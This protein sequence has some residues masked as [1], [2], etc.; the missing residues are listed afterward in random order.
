MSEIFSMNYSANPERSFV[1]RETRALYFEIENLAGRNELS[2]SLEN[3]ATAGFNA[4]YIEAFADLTTSFPVPGHGKAAV[5]RQRSESA[6]YDMLDYFCRQ[7]QLRKMHAYAVVSL[8]VERPLSPRLKWTAMRE[9]WFRDGGKVLCFANEH[10]R[11]RLGDLASYLV[12][13]YPLDGLFL[14]I[15]PNALQPCTCKQCTNRSTATPLP[16]DSTGSLAAPPPDTWENDVYQFCYSFKSRARKAQVILPLGLELPLSRINE[17]SQGSMKSVFEEQLFCLILL[18]AEQMG[19]D[20]V[21]KAL[22]ELDPKVQEKV[23]LIRTGKLAHF[24]EDWRD[25]GVLG[26]ALTPGTDPLVSFADA[27]LPIDRDPLA[28]ALYFLREAAKA[29]QTDPSF[30]TALLARVATLEA[31]ILTTGTLEA[32][33]NELAVLAESFEKNPTAD[34]TALNI[35]LS[36]ANRMLLLASS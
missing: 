12:E 6:G 9:R 17:I 34:T 21:E 27:A 23:P 8:H 13:T 36:N 16:S 32:L 4:A 5:F 2:K 1:R 22:E 7:A 30:Q 31:K 25:A 3:G 11:R 19:K 26:L 24:P 35:S 28:A 18:N 20:Q 33:E 15:P 29:A 14:R 10:L